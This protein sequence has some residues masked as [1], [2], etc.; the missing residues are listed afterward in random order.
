MWPSPMPSSG[1]PV[2]SRN[3]RLLDVLTLPRKHSLRTRAR[4][5]PQ[6]LT[7]T[8][9]HVNHRTLPSSSDCSSC[10]TLAQKCPESV[11]SPQLR[12]RTIS[13]LEIDNIQG[14]TRMV[15][16]CHRSVGA[17]LGSGSFRNTTCRLLCPV[18]GTGSAWRPSVNPAWV[19]PTT[20][21]FATSSPKKRQAQK[22]YPS[23]HCT[24]THQT[25]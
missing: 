14:C 15:R 8:L 12:M 11:P 3:A 4:L 16:W 9:V 7:R 19:V 2:I 17:A 20:A 10:R 13:V 1:T 25:H 18:C 21:L 5:P 23:V 6:V 22:R 24:G